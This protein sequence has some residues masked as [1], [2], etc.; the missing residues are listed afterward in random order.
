MINLD[1]KIINAVARQLSI[2]YTGAKLTELMT[3]VIKVLLASAQQVDGQDEDSKCV[4]KTFTSD[5]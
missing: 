2:L 3:E 4:N 5:V 1:H